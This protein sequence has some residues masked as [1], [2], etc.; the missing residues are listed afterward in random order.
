MPKV[1]PTTYEPQSD[2][3]DGSDDTRGGRKIGDPTL[4]QATET[5]GKTGTSSESTGAKRSTDER[6]PG[7]R[8][9]IG[10]VETTGY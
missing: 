10:D 5:G 2:S 4:D 7:E 9:S 8:P 6:L 1:D 3:P